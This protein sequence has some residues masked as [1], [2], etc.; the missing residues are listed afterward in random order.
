MP[1]SNNSFTANTRKGKESSSPKHFSPKDYVDCP[2]KEMQAV[3][4]L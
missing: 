2:E 4:K 1:E 3:R